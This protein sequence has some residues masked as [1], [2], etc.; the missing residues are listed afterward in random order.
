MC[1]PTGTGLV[2]VV[3]VRSERGVTNG[4]GLL[5]QRKPDR[6]WPSSGNNNLAAVRKIRFGD[7]RNFRAGTVKV[8]G[9]LDPSA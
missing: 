9:T 7:W 5:E 2:G 6:I 3:Y 1:S 4:P 8:Q